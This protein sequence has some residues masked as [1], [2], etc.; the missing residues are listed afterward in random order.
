MLG[1]SN[2]DEAYEMAQQLFRYDPYTVKVAPTNERSNPIMEPDR[3]QYLQLADWIQSLGHR[4]CIMRRYVSEKA[5]EEKIQ[6]VR[7]TAEKF[8][9]A[10]G[11][12]FSG[13][14]RQIDSG[15][16]CAGARCF[17]GNQPEI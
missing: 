7:K 1:L 16:W 13:G 8:Q 15:T 12:D 2:H 17:R 14:E 4:Q 9:P 10:S 5:I 3:G 6:F 11:D